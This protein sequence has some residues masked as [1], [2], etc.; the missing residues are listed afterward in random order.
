MMEAFVY[1]WFDM[2]TGKRY[3]GV[4]KG[5]PEDGYVCSSKLMLLEYTKRPQEF[6]RQI[7]RHGAWKEMLA[8]EQELIGNCD[9]VKNP[10]FY[11]QSCNIGRHHSDRTGTTLTGKNK[12]RWLGNRYAVGCTRSEEHKKIISQIKSGNQYG[13]GYKHSNEFKTYMTTKKNALGARYVRPRVTC[14]KCHKTGASN[15]MKRY[16]FNNCRKKSHEVI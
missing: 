12:Q 2:G 3:I 6:R 13:L 15:L 11:N 5:S 14:P 7:M 4:H 1:M 10:K 16:H 8:K 9:A